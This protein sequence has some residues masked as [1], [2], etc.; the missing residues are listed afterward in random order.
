MIYAINSDTLNE[1]NPVQ[2]VLK[3]RWTRMC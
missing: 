1:N 3:R 2:P